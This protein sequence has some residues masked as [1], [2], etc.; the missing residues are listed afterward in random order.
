MVDPTGM[1][2][3]KDRLLGL[4][5]EYIRQGVPLQKMY[6]NIQTSSKFVVDE[7]IGITPLGF[8][9]D[10][11][12]IQ[13]QIYSGKLP[14]TDIAKLVSSEGFDKAFEVFAKDTGVSGMKKEAYAF[15]IKQLIG[16]GVDKGTSEKEKIA[17]RENSQSSTDEEQTSR[18]KMGM[19]K[20]KDCSF[21]KC[22]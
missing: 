18:Q 16:Y 1:V 2:G 3:Q 13:H 5:R 17:N 15:V 9:Y 8:A 12:K 10:I 11:V 4:Q 20:V 14:V 6:D 19:P 21:G 7:A 22:K